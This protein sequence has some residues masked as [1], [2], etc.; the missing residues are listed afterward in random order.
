MQLDR[1]ARLGSLTDLDALRSELVEIAADL[2][3]GRVA[4]LLVTEA[5]G[6]PSHFAWVGNTPEEFREVFDDPALG[7]QD[8]VM[9]HL[10]Q[11]CTPVIYDQSTYVSANAAPLWEVQAPFGYRTGIVVS[12]RLNESTRYALGID[13][14]AAISSHPDHRARLV[15]EVMMLAAF[16]AET[17]LRLLGE[18]PIPTEGQPHLTTR[19]R[20]ILS[21]TLR[22]K[23]TW[24]VGQLMGLSEG[25]VNF[26]LRNA[27]RKL[28]V[29]SRFTAASLALRLG[30]ICL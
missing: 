6:R 16:S 18:Q 2:D 17:A 9:Q 5:A 11:R 21:W 14:D 1:V 15:G 24:V 23:S 25:T 26:H 12:M 3:F 20:E 19:E 28:G 13:R 30:L 4:G 8:P 29:S 27:M 22:G 10:R 7:Q